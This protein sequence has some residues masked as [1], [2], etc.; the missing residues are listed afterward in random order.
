MFQAQSFRWR[1]AGALAVTAGLLGWP[2]A[3]AAQ[4]VAGSA[5]AARVT[6]FDLLRGATTTALADT[7]AL[8][9]AADARQAWMLTGRVGSVL[10]ADVLR[11]VTLGWPDQVTSEASVATLALTV[12]GIP[13]SADLV[14]ATAASVAGATGTAASSIDN[15]AINGVPIVVSG[16]P[17]QTIPIPG[18]RVVLNEQALSSGAVTVNA[19]H[20]TVFG[21]A[22]VVVA[23]A[24]AGIQ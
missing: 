13:I 9:G 5:R 17:N 23:S 22:D 10:S 18:G 15:L 1:A 21:V 2:A 12:A 7:G 14:T 3:V 24:T 4:T 11:A 8:G 19:I 20:A 6:T 16:E